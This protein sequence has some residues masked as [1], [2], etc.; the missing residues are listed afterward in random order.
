MSRRP[1]PIV[2]PTRTR[3]LAGS[4]VRPRIASRPE[5]S[6]ES[7]ESLTAQDAWLD[8]LADIVVADLLQQEED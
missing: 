7:P 2:S 3:P 4:R 8:L 1:T 6:L 5:A